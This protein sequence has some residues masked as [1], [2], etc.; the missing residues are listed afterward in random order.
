MNHISESREKN[1]YGPNDK[2]PQNNIQHVFL[3]LKNILIGN[4]IVR[5]KV[6]IIK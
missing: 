6:N 4:Q 3:I 1:Y 2:C 5:K